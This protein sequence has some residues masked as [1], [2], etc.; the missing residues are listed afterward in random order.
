MSRV[1]AKKIVDT[2]KSGDVNL[3][4]YD[5]RLETL[6]PERAARMQGQGKQKIHTQ[7]KTRGNMYSAVK[8]GGQKLCDLARKGREVERK[9]RNITIY[10][11]ELLEQTGEGDW[12]LRCACSKGTYIRTL[13]HDIGQ[14]LGCG[15]ALS[16]L[17]RTMAAGFTLEQTVSLDDMQRLGESLLLPTDRYFAEYPAYA[18]RSKA[19]ETRCRNGNPVTDAALSDGTYRVY[20]SDGT[21]LCLSEARGGTLTSVKNFFGA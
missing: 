9:P 20:G 14:M 11:L 8:I 4:K 5:E 6:A 1:P 12:M 19:Q 13:A 17:R 15:A 10:E 3:A 16:S 18:V 2:R 21:F 7:N